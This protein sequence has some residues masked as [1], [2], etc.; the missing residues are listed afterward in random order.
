LF[1]TVE[2]RVHDV[3]GGL[4]KQKAHSTFDSQSL[5]ANAPDCCKMPTQVLAAVMHIA[6][7]NIIFLENTVG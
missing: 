4:R 3:Q 7:I 2:T 6:S 5:P 1:S